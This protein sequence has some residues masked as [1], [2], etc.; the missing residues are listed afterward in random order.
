MVASDRSSLPV[1]AGPAPQEEV[2]EGE[3]TDNV[4]HDVPDDSSESDM[5]QE[6]E[7]VELDDSSS[8]LTEELRQI[9]EQE[10]YDREGDGEEEEYLQFHEEH[11]EVASGDERS[12]SDGS[13]NDDVD[14]DGVASPMLSSTSSEED[15]T[16]RSERPRRMRTAPKVL[17]YNSPG[18]PSY[19]HR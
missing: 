12:A 18:N 3:A 4:V 10:E 15:E 14:E 5:A 17:Q 9:E 8:G 6:E 7:Q 16:S 13:G 2:P 19:G 11:F 1:E